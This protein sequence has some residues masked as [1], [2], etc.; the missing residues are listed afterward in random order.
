MY[1]ILIA[2][3]ST[4]EFDHFFWLFFVDE[5][6]GLLLLFLLFRVGGTRLGFS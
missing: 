4:T 6:R 5:E 1:Q 2:D 3:K